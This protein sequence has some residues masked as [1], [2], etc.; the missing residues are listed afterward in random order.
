MLRRRYREN[1]PVENPAEL[2]DENKNEINEFDGMSVDELKLYAEEHS[3]DIG[4]STSQ[5]G[6]LKKIIEATKTE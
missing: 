2:L 1:Q 5:K 3:I 4:Q 6:I